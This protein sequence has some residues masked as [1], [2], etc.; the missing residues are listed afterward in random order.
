MKRG[1]SLALLLLF[2][3]VVA[4]EKI[5]NYHS[6]VLVRS[7]GW[8]EVAETIVVQA[9]G[10]QIRRGI[11]RDY[12]TDYKDRYGND[13]RVLYEPRAVFRNDQVE[14]FFSEKNRNGIRTYFGSADRMLETGIHTYEYR[15]DAGRMLGFFENHDELYW[16][17]TGNGWQFPI[18][19]ATATV[20]FA[21][22]VDADTLDL[23][24]ATGAFGD[25]GSDFQAST[26]IT[27]SA[28]FESTQRFFPTRVCGI[29]C[30][31]TKFSTRVP[32]CVG[33]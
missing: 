18:E 15:Y 33:S 28:N 16:N 12:P 5:L 8:L 17:V 24:A 30:Y 27:G 29:P 31:C 10:Q 1:A 25:F 13:V 3:T 6:D 26:D 14:D 23:T 22:D 4:E 9:E 2:S 7:D 11:Y 21:F 20:T 32:N 19:N